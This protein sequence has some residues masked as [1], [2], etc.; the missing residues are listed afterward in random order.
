MNRPKRL[1]PAQMQRA[2]DK[3]NAAHA[4][5]DKILCWPGSK[6]VAPSEFTIS[7]PAGILGG[8]T[9]VVYV[10]G[11]GCIALSHVCG[12]AAARPAPLLTDAEIPF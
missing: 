7:G 11:G 3:F 4:V 9:A 1:S 8:H 6:Q 5:G 2:C 12:E 10:S